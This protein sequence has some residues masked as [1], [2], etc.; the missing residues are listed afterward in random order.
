MGQ[1]LGGGGRSRLGQGAW[2]Y[3]LTL[4]KK[5]WDWDPGVGRNEG[6]GET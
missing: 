4:D 3:S 5:I 1:D 2:R 6:E